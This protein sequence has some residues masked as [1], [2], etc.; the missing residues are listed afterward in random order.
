[1]PTRSPSTRLDDQRKD[2]INPEGAYEGNHPKQLQTHNLPTL[3]NI[4]NINKGR[5]LLLANNPQFA[6]WGTER[7]QRIQRHRR[8][9]LH[10]SAHPKREQDETE[11]SSYDLDWQQKGICYGLPK[12]DNKLPQNAQ[13]IRC[14]HKL[15]R[16]NHENL[17]SGFDSRRERGI[18]QRDTLLPLIFIIEMVPLNHIL[19]KYTAGYKLSKSQETINHLKYM[20]NNKLFEKNEKEAETLIHAVRIYSQDIETEFGR[21]KCA[22]LVTKSG[23]RHLTDGME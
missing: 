3:E 5:D 4:N 20:D 2:H 10:R 22:M 17:E 21:E 11:K 18:F 1:M 8:V 6:P 14:S 7:M 19:R 15:Y 23:K 16:E 9:T 12:L 13:N